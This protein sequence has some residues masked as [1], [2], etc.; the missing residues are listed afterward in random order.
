M[1][2]AIKKA[3]EGGWRDRF[4]SKN[5]KNTEAILV[6]WDAL[7]DPLFWQALGKALGWEEKLQHNPWKRCWHRFTDHIASGKDADSFFTNLLT[8]S[9]G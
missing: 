7:L 4:L 2:Q 3:I 5:H 8:P 1:E 9:Q 6:Q